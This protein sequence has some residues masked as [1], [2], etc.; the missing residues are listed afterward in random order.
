MLRGLAFS[1]DGS[2]LWS[3]SLD[4]SVRRWDLSTGKQTSE[5]QAS[6]LGVYGIALRPDGTQIAVAS[7]DE[8]RV[9]VWDT[10]NSQTVSTTPIGQGQVV[11]LSFSSD[12]KTLLSGGANGTLRVA[13]QP[14]NQSET[15]TGSAATFQPAAGLPN[16]RLAIINETG[17]LLLLSPGQRGAPLEG[18]GSR[19]LAVTASPDGS[20]IAAAAANGTV[21]V[22]DA[23]T[24]QVRATLR[25]KLAFGRLV[26]FSADGKSLAAAG[27]AVRADQPDQPLVE[28][29]NI[30]SGKVSA[31]LS[32]I[33]ARVIG[34]AFQPRGTVL[35]LL[36]GDGSIEI[37]QTTSAARLRQ[38]Q[39]TD[40]EGR[41]AGLAFGPDG[42]TL[43]SGAQSGEL[44]FWNLGGGPPTRLPLNAGVPITLALSPDGER[45]AVSL[46]SDSNPVE[47]FG[48]P[49]R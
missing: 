44:L 15:I 8:G 1:A 20:S 47:I 16:G 14:S 13:Q 33:T 10:A 4:G 38:I 24:G 27:S 49:G 34:V 7:N 48:L 41:F 29:W 39:P 45:L 21:V 42:A 31:T 3:G 11:S 17:A 23:A 6:D 26:A 18:L 46:R 12:S 22:W 43:I 25:G 19:A 37:W 40:A 36:L 28:V 2:A 32:G 35:G 5:I 9:T 30:E